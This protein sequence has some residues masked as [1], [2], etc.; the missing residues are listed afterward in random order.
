M[1]N[2][3]NLSIIVVVISCGILLTF[4]DT[5]FVYE[6]HELQ[7]LWNIII[8]LVGVAIGFLVME[9]D[10]RSHDYAGRFHRANSRL[11]QEFERSRKLENELIATRS[12]KKKLERELL[13]KKQ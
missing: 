11:H 4:L 3:L 1:N 6:P 12:E 5:L 9:R 2:F 7:I 13:W 10:T 8:L